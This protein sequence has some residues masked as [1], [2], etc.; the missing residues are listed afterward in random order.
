M[1]ADRGVGGEASVHRLVAPIHRDEVH[2]HIDEQVALGD[3]PA[4]A[5]LLAQVRLAYDDVPVRVLGVVVIE[6]VRVVAGHD[7]APQTMLELG[8][9]HPAVQAEGRDE[10]NILD[11][12][13]GSLLQY[14]FD[15]LLTNV[16]LSHRWQRYREVVEGDSQLH[17][18]PEELV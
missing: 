4:D 18:R 16:W 7:P 6:P 12:L 13:G 10:V 8:F 14:L 17:A 3:A 9:C 11:T 1:M 2:V 15:N 5:D